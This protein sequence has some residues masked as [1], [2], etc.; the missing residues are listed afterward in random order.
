MLPIRSSRSESHVACRQGGGVGG[1][2]CRGQRSKVQTFA[3]RRE[4][5]GLSRPR[6]KPNRFI[7][8]RRGQ[9]LAGFPASASGRRRRRQPAA[10]SV[11]RPA[12]RSMGEPRR[13]AKALRRRK[14]LI[15][16]AYPTLRFPTRQADSSFL[17]G[18]TG[19][20]CKA[21]GSERTCRSAKILLYSARNVRRGTWLPAHST[22]LARCA[23]WRPPASI[24]SG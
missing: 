10:G 16:Q 9:T 8:R 7:P 5:R 17:V 24:R 1:R 3:V 2:R 4:Q 12:A 6:E 15:A 23:A 13:A 21:R 11:T 20:R 14:S 22:R 18:T 19:R